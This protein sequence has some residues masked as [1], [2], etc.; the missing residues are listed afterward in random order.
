MLHFSFVQ[1]IPHLLCT[2]FHTYISCLFYR[3]ISL[4]Y[5]CPVGS[6]NFF[7][8]MDL[9]SAA[10]SVAASP[11]SPSSSYSFGSIDTPSERSA[12]SPR[13]DAE[14]LIDLA[15]ENRIARINQYGCDNVGEDESFFVADLGE[16][17]R[18][19]QRWTRN[20]PGVQPFYGNPFSHH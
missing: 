17:C 9:L 6:I 4:C 13:N 20:L 2:S 16:I 5:F 10:S 14:D 15:I 1:S 12:G 19:H 18:Q 8:I 7:T 3:S 11:S